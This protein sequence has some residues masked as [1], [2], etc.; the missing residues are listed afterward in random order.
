MAPEM[1][2]N[3]GYNYLIDFY[4]LGALLYELLVGFPPFQSKKTAELYNS[5]LNEELTFPDEAGLSY[6][7]INLIEKLME[8]IP[9]KRIG[10]SAGISEV[11]NHPWLSGIDFEDIKKRKIKATFIPE[12]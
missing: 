6:E 3:D 2:M 4:C 5:I 1:L 9:S 12:I 11:L 7:A 8:K 10:S